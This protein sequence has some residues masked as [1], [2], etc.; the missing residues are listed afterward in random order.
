[1]WCDL[2]FEFRALYG[3]GAMRGAIDEETYRS[4]LRSFIEDELLLGEEEIEDD[5][6][7]IADG[8]L[9]SISIVSLFAFLEEELGLTVP[10]ESVPIEELES[11]ATMSAWVHSLSSRSSS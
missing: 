9:D 4:Q 5:T 11:L 3:S 7:L 1:M 2:G 6:A 8:V 10:T